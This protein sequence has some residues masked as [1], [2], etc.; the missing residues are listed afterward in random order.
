MIA[1]MIVYAASR[2]SRAARR[3]GLLT[4]SV[5]LWSRGRRQRAA[6]QAH[7]AQCHAVVRRAITSCARQNTVVVLGSGLVRDVPMAALLAAFQR[8]ILIDVVHLPAVRWRY[9][10]HPRVQMISRDLTGVLDWMM[11]EA[12]ARR[13]PLADVR[14]DSQVDL[15]ISANLLSQL[16]IA[17]ENWLDDNPHRASALPADF[18]P[19]LI[20][21][22]LAD[23]TALPSQVCLLTD[24]SMV[25]RTRG[26]AACDTLDLM[27]GCPVPA[28]DTQWDWTVAPFGE[29]ERDHEYIHHVHGY[30]DFHAA[31]ARPQSD[32][33][34]TAA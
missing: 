11:G 23:L 16:P 18:L 31:L 28:P 32:V 8:V 13:D 1:E 20:R 9:G 29:I 2:A 30:A 25:E 4:E 34:R 21:W 33:T 12:D 17:L 22:H 26:G 10:R 14:A 3:A 5:G 6:W 19:S 7:E 27:R 15:V 24:V